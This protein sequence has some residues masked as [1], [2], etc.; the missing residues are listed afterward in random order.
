[1]DSMPQT[2]EVP[3]EFHRPAYTATNIHSPQT[4][5]WDALNQRSSD[6]AT[7]KGYVPTPESITRK[8]SSV[9]DIT[10]YGPNDGKTRP[11]VVGKSLMDKILDWQTE[12][13]FEIVYSDPMN[14][15]S[16][17]L[18]KYNN[19]FYTPEAFELMVQRD[20]AA[21]KLKADL[22]SSPKE[23]RSVYFET[24]SSK[25]SDDQKAYLDDYRAGKYTLEGHADKRGSDKKNK[26]L[27]ED[28]VDAVAQELISN[29]A[30]VYSFEAYGEEK[31]TAKTKEG[32]ALERRVDILPK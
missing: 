15:R 20:R 18:I 14:S 28:R 21:A 10:E 5:N 29:G 11:Q 19:I 26:K 32:M 30:E 1:M 31:A 6:P 9:S 22:A 27:S 17:L 24:N 25:V 8:D 3:Y 4:N 2:I 13:A 7:L 16:D 12:Y 23:L